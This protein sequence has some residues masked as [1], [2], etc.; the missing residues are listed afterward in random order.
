LTQVTDGKHWDDK[1]RW[2]PDGKTIY[3]VT[4]RGGFL[5]VWGIRFDPAQGQPVGE[6]F[7]VT[8]FESPSQMV[9]PRIAPLNIA[10]T[11]DRLFLNI[12]EMSGSVWV[13]E[14]VDR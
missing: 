12:T 3:F 6:P 1:P 10:L 14:N 2:A 8:A 7:R 9:F 13:V 4:N 11:A 5:N